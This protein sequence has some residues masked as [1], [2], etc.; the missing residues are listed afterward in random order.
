[1]GRKS[2]KQLAKEERTLKQDQKRAALFF[3]PRDTTGDTVSVPRAPSRSKPPLQDISPNANRSIKVDL[4][5]SP[6]KVFLFF[7][8]SLIYI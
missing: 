1:M 4:E 2:K 7:N 5:S 3:K 6:L 8:C